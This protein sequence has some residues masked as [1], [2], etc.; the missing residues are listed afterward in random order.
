MQ[1]SIRHLE[2]KTL[3]RDE[4]YLKIHCPPF[5]SLILAGKRTLI[6]GETHNRR[7]MPCYVLMFIDEGTVYFTEENHSYILQ[8]GMWFTQ[9]PGRLHYGHKTDSRQASYYW[10]HFMPT[11]D[12][13][14]Q[15]RKDLEVFKNFNTKIINGGQGLYPPE[16][17]FMFPL[18][19]TYPKEGWKILL[20][21]I[22]MDI[23]PMH[24]N[25]INKQGTFNQLL[26]LMITRENTK[27]G[28]DENVLAKEILDY[29]KNNY[30]TRIK[31]FDI[32]NHFH[33]SPDYITRCMKN[34]FGTTPS[35]VM[36]ILRIE[37]AK[38]L[39]DYTSRS[40]ENI[41]LE[42]GFADACVFSR[43][44]KTRVGMSPE[45]YRTIQKKCRTPGTL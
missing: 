3:P 2:V 13:Q 30:S 14:L 38:E 44:F 23:D 7:I 24:W 36:A 17:D 15:N 11:G 34:E 41:G 4:K 32:A 27:K 28:G 20:N 26:Y 33:F 35:E 25:Y 43:A 31:V 1:T 10:I 29:I 40:I 39:L 21:E 9:I 37:K 12:C 19:H 42:T 5:P 22:C 8:E 6:P 16:Y 45:R 18:S